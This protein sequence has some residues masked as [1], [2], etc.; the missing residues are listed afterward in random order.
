MIC[1]PTGSRSRVS[2]QGIDIPGRPA[3]LMVTVKMSDRYID[4]GSS[5]LSPNRKAGVGDVGVT[6]ASTFSKARS[7]SRR[8]RVRT[9]CPFS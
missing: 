7:K 5:S 8:M 2:P 6:M 3:R 4:N 9:F 1:S